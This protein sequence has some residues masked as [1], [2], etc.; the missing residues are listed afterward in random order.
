VTDP[1]SPPPWRPIPTAVRDRILNATEEPV[2]RRRR[3]LVG[4]AAGSVVL[5]VGAVFTVQTVGGGHTGSENPGLDRCAAAVRDSAELPARSEWEQVFESSFGEYKVIAARAAAKPVFCELTNTAVTVSIAEPAYV[6]GTGAGLVLVTPLGT[7]A[8]AIDPSW[9]QPQVRTGDLVRSPTVV[10]GLFI[11]GF[12]GNKQ[13][14]EVADGANPANWITLP[15]PAHS[16]IRVVDARQ[17]PPP[18]RTS[19][20]GQIV[21]DC[22]NAASTNRGVIDP[23]SWEPGAMVKSNE[24]TLIA[25]RNAYG[26]SSCWYSN[27]NPYGQFSN[28]VGAGLYQAGKTANQGPAPRLFPMYHEAYDQGILVGVVPAETRRVQVL[29]ARGPTVEADVANS[30]F[31]AL[32]PPGEIVGNTDA[33]LS[34][35]LYDASGKVTYE[36]R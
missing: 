11:S 17:A 34:F 6:R 26:Y 8:G 32:T 10:D 30:T 35:R 4:V 19:P 1:L 33:K 28:F 5:A 24:G 36:G 12:K 16:P 22:I 13:E 18:D 20:R 29:I 9:R 31:A 7:I 15:M 27:K 23:D 25:V 14:V 2:V 21:S 3:P